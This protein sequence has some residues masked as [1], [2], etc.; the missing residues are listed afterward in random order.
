MTTATNNGKAMSNGQGNNGQGN[1][2]NAVNNALFG[3]SLGA[4]A[5]AD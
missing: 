5:H 4:F 3:C 2:I 1:T